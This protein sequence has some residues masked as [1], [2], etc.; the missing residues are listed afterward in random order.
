M[1]TYKTP[2]VYVNETPLS[3][4]VTGTNGGPVAAFFG[5]AQRGPATPTLVTNWS[6]YKTLF[7]D[8][9]TD[10]DLPYAV[11]HYF[12]NGGRAAYVTRV[13]DTTAT[14]ATLTA[15]PYYPT[16]NGNASASAFTVTAKSPGTWGND[17]GV[18]TLIG[19]EEATATARGTFT[20]VI[21][22]DGSEVERW[23]ELSLDPASS[24]YVDSI[25]NNYSQFVEL[26]AIDTTASD[27]SEEF[28]DV[29]VPIAL[30]GAIEGTANDTDYGTAVSLLDSIKG[31]LIINMVGRSSHTL[32]STTLAYAETRGDS[33]VVVDPDSADTTV[34]EVTAWAA[35]FQGITGA[36][37]GA[38][39]SPML[40]MV[41]P[42]RTG[43]G[44]IRSTYP[45]GAIAGIMSRT[46][47]ER[48]VAKAPAGITSDVRGALGIE[49][50]LTDAEIGTLYDGNAYVNSFK[51]ISGAGISVYGAR[52]MARSA[53]DKFIPVRRTLNYVK[54][55]LQDIT[56]FA[57][58]E[59]N[60][61]SLWNRLNSV[62][63]SF[64]GEL[65]RQGGL[66]GT[67][68]NQA[69]YIVCDSTNNTQSTID[70]GLV[71]IE[72]GVA[73]TYPAE[74]IV[75]NLS[76]WTGGSNAVESL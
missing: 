63:S 29:Q 17:L 68:V 70:Q 66:A 19:N 62:V 48:S 58:F 50:E 44:A 10:Y 49:I 59:P 60:G 69:F 76:Q 24:R 40:K 15:V 1:P 13:V 14:Q 16:G 52:T 51:A 71:N 32:A 4:L 3:T 53:P 37:Y 47:I 38:L 8:V 57:V 23:P 2:G 39:Y 33:F 12:A 72:V 55:G 22:I 7:G 18:A 31:N 46:E 25:V 34:A 56:E 73:L 75:I 35:N 21:Y 67:S 74:F 20:L 65:W 45:G 6:S 9:T 11:Y 41:D 61:V 28:I 54:S 42:A 27:A 43:P 26:S 30:S 36:G 64:L 5:E